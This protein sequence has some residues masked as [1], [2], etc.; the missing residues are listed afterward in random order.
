MKINIKEEM[1]R[2]QEVPRIVSET[3]V[4]ANDVLEEALRGLSG[5]LLYHVAQHAAH[6]IEASRGSADVTQTGVVKENLM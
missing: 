4:T 5:Q 2:K 1:K 6:R 3:Q